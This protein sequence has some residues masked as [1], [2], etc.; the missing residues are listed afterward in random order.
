[1]TEALRQQAAEI[2]L[3]HNQSEANRTALEIE[4]MLK[5]AKLEA[6]HAAG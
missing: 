5:A 2:E 3:R 1:M 6:A 4:L